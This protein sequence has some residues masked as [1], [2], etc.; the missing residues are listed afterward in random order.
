MR[1]KKVLMFV[2]AVIICVPSVRAG[3]IAGP[4]LNPSN[5]HSYYLL[6]QNN[7]SGSEAEAVSLGGH[8]VTINDAAEDAFVSSSFSGFGDVHRALWIG[9]N[10]SAV[11]GT[12]V[13]VS[14]E[15]VTYTNWGQYEPNN[16]GGGEDWAHIF[17]STD[18][19]FPHWNDAP[20]SADAFGFVFN[21]VVEVAS[22]VPEPATLI[23]WSL[24]GGLG[25]VFGVWRRRKAA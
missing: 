21:G 22:Q 14:G 3:I 2:V 12:F 10:D 25:I 8:L 24:L 13:W 4:L 19:R 11:E 5:G 1:S 7:W 20:N 16:S 9:L 15:P 23:V 18:N 17:P 6:S